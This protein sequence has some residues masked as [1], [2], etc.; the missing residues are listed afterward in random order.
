MQDIGDVLCRIKEK[1]QWTRNGSEVCDESGKNS[2]S[3][4]SII[5]VDPP[6]EW[7]IY[8][9]KVG[10][11]CFDETSFLKDFD[12]SCEFHKLLVIEL[13]S[14]SIFPRITRRIERNTKLVASNS[15]TFFP[16]WNMYIFCITEYNSDPINHD[17]VI[18]RKVSQES[19]THFIANAKDKIPTS[20]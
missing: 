19:P 1:P 7:F 14:D 3:F 10:S 8:P 12:C 11:D 4:F 15:V 20:V 6:M 16:L 18:V 9:P 5:V 17:K 13:T 2:Y